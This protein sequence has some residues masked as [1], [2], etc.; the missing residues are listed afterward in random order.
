VTQHKKLELDTAE[1]AHMDQLLAENPTKF[2]AYAINDTRVTLEYYIQFM[3]QYKELFGTEALPLTLGD[4]AVKAYLEALDRQGKD[5]HG[6]FGKQV[7]QV[8]NTLG[9]DMHVTDQ[10]PIRKITNRLAADTFMG[11]MNTSYKLG[12]YHDPDKVILDIDFS[13]AYAAALALIP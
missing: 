2:A 8:R 3:N 1:I 13:G 6:L 10:V 7:V 11:G 4:G 5:Y 12:E 9:H